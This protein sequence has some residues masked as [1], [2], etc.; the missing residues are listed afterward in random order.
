MEWARLQ[1]CHSRVW[2]ETIAQVPDV[3]LPE[4]MQRKKQ[5]VSVAK[6]E[7]GKKL[8]SRAWG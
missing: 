4:L 3:L 8:G 1:K 6:S 2:L 5:L 7:R